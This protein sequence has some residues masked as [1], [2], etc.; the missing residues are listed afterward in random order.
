MCCCFG[1]TYEMLLRLDEL[2]ITGWEFQC[3][4]LWGKPWG[5]MNLRP[6]SGRERFV[7]YR[8]DRLYLFPTQGVFLDSERTFY[9]PKVVANT[10]TPGVSRCRRS[11]RWACG[12]CCESRPGWT[13]INQSRCSDLHSL[14]LSSHLAAWHCW[15]PWRRWLPS[16]WSLRPWPWRAGGCRLIWVNYF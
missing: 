7:S 9:G 11:G 15:E 1:P 3:M 2:P 5:L 12:A 10:T 14:L 6:S 16:W 8:L 4:L 13:F